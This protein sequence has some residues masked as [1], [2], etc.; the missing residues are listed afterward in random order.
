MVSRIKPPGIRDG[1]ARGIFLKRR[2]IVKK[3][4]FFCVT[5]I[6][7]LASCD[8]CNR[9]LPTMTDIS[10]INV[11]VVRDAW[12]G[13]GN[14]GSCSGVVIHSPGGDRENSAPYLKQL[15]V[16]KKLHSAGLAKWVRLDATSAY[17]NAYFRQLK[18][19]GYFVFG[20]ISLE[21]FQNAPT[22]EIAFEKIYGMYP[23]ADVWEIAG[24]V[25][26]GDPTVNRYPISQEE[27]MVHLR[28]L[29]AYIQTAYPEL[30]Q[31]YPGS[32]TGCSRIVS[33]PTFGSGNPGEELQKYYKLGITN[34]PGIIIAINDYGDIAADTY[35]NIVN[36]H[37][38][39]MGRHEV[40]V[41]ETGQPTDKQI[42]WNNSEIPQ[43]RKFASKVFWYSMSDNDIHSYGLIDNIGE[44]GPYTMRPLLEALLKSTPAS[45][46]S[47][48]SFNP[49]P[50]GDPIG[51][52][53]VVR[54]PR[55]E[56]DL[57]SRNQK[58][59]EK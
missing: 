9:S 37:A 38:A 6:I 18:A 40:W 52:D 53:P 31:S 28:Q 55:G 43:L 26:N 49:N 4:L 41:T 42:A 5:A 32:T 47:A 27:Y 30:M 19:E 56:R 16:M 12:L 35:E 25:M 50:F 34:L 8:G 21:E 33:A 46:S 1:D 17:V 51:I 54:P 3:R 44:T 20:I 59:R 36:A 22:W 14:D 57:E 13:Q 23:E 48:P 11:N 24:E 15:D 39:E 29:Y 10:Q 58:E 7:L 45:G 2:N